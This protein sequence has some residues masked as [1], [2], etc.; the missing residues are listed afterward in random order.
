MTWVLENC[1]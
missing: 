1:W